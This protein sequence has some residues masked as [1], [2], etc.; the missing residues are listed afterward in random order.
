MERVPR[1]KT[2]HWNLPASRRRVSTGLEK[3]YNPRRFRS[4]SGRF[5][6]RSVAT[7]QTTKNDHVRWSRKMRGTKF[8]FCALAASL[9]F[10]GNERLH[11]QTIGYA[12][13]LGEL[14]VSCG[15]DIARFCGRTN[16]GGGAVADCLEQHVA[17]VSPSC[18][19]TAAATGA[20]LRKRAAARACRSA[21]LR[22][23]SASVLRRHSARRRADT[24]LHVQVEA[25]LEAGVPAGAGRFRL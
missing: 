18:R 24:G 4:H 15:N 14:A 13:A 3:L 7:V 20:L 11:A 2:Y 9:L 10:A 6:P 17:N 25:R 19:S 5:R 12:E 22:I 23:G 1:R 8:A 21:A 16:L